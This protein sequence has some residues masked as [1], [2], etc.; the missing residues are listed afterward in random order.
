MLMVAA[1]GKDTDE[2]ATFDLEQ[3]QPS[4]YSAPLR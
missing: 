3:F 2:S 4:A 1:K